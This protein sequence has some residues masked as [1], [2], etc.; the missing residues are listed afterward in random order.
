MPRNSAILYRN[1]SRQPGPDG[2]HYR[3]L[4]RLLDDG[5]TYWVGLWPRTVHGQL[6]YEI[7]LSP[8]SEN[9]R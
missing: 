8:K 2:S 1:P 4:M 3:G 5:R 6:V 9:R 7:K